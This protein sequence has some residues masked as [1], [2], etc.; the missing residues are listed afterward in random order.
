MEN[1]LSKFSAV[2]EFKRNLISERTQSG[3]E[4]ARRNKLLGRPKGCNPE[5][6]E[7]YQ[8][9][10]YLYDNKNIPIENS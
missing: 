3:L 7:K 9:A 4:G 10:K 2:A 1:L 5:D 6:I 8:Y